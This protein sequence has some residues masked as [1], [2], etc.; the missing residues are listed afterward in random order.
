MECV[1]RVGEAHSLHTKAR[2]LSYVK[3]FE[4]FDIRGGG[5]AP[6][7]QTIGPNGF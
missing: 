2:M 4:D 5:R 6:K 1:G 3:S 7:L